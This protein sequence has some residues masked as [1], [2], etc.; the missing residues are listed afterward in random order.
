MQEAKDTARALVRIGYDGTVHKL[1]RAKDA[2]ERFENEI[3]VLKY[4]E[5]RGCDFVPRVLDYNSE[6]LELVT[7][8]C[9]ARVQQ[10]TDEKLKQIFDELE[11]YG[12]RHDDPY[13]RNITYRAQD[14]RF[15]VIDF[16][17][18][19]ILDEE[20][21]AS[22]V[23][24][25]EQRVIP[26]EQLKELF[27]KWSGTT[28]PGKFR[29]NNED[30]F[31]A[32]AFNMEEFIYLASRGDVPVGDFDYIFAVS[33]GM[34]G[35]RSGEFASK[36]ALDNITRLMSRRFQ[37]SPAHNQ[38]GIQDCLEE[39]F[40]GIHRQ[41]TTLGQ[42][43]DEGHNMGATM[44]L[45]W[46]CAG[47]IHFGHIGDS[48]IY[49]LPPD[50]PMT[51]ITDDHTHVG[52]LKRQGKINEREAR[53]HP[54]KNVL[55]QALG[56]GNQFVNPHIGA[57]RARKGDRFLLCT[58][59]VTDGLWDRALEDLLRNPPSDVAGMPPSQVV[60]Q[61]AIAEN[62]RDNATAISLEIH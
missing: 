30:A 13:L 28:D 39:L 38:S 9:G 23:S 3:R 7:S 24:S 6:K 60:V 29:P 50:G 31:I 34:G 58:D 44:S 62:G 25:G 47:Y 53:M 41:L 26:A 40:Q 11:A 27:L 42:S 5:E 59:G 18:A 4:L 49:Y 43:Y 61:T 54:R 19:T 36:L 8:N 55:A 46:Y 52:W 48:R 56:A 12:V 15:C 10:I 51:Q 35:E 32:V 1:F 20:A 57:I 21:A 37:F 16:E 17:F 45:V 2:R 22:A 14:G 33:D